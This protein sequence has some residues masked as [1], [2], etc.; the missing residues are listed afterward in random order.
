M[1]LDKL[2]PLSS[3]IKIFGPYQVIFFVFEPCVLRSC[4]FYAFYGM[5][6]AAVTDKAHQ[7]RWSDKH[8][9]CILLW[10]YCRHVVTTWVINPAV[11][12][13]NDT[14]PRSHISLSI[15]LF[16]SVS[17]PENVGGRI[18]RIW[19]CIENNT[20]HLKILYSFVV[21]LLKSKYVLSIKQES[22]IV[23]EWILK[24]A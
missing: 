10:R 18:S 23:L 5:K 24:V 16:S 6:K 7:T 22:I 15:M 14:I 19:N 20:K 3:S 13:P 8:E 17:E 2:R 11:P 1:C 4:I 9:S 21:M 12:G